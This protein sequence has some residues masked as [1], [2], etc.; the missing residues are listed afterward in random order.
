M[1]AKSI[2]KNILFLLVLTALIHL[3]CNSSSIID[4][5]NNSKQVKKEV[6]KKDIVLNIDPVKILPNLFKVLLENQHVRVV[7]YSLKPGEK[8][9]W[10]THPPKSSYV[11]SGGKLKVYLES[12]EIIVAD[13]EAGTAS[14]MDEAGKHYV[15]NIGTT[16]VT[17]VYTEIKQKQ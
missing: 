3:G 7:Q 16:T 2:S 11:V 13:E 1:K 6:Q 8:D 5:K 14:W 10:H 12:G 4:K 9:G 17:I 15:E